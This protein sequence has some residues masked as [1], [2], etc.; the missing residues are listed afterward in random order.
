M[1]D[2]KRQEA[3]KDIYSRVLNREA[4]EGGLRAYYDS[5]LT[6]KQIEETIACSDEALLLK[7][8]EIQKEGFLSLVEPWLYVGAYVDSFKDELLKEN[9]IAYVLEITNSENSVFFNNSE[10]QTEIIKIPNNAVMSISDT[11]KCLSLINKALKEG[12]NLLICDSYGCI[13]APAI[14]VLWYIAIG[15]D[16]EAAS[17]LVSSKVSIISMDEMLLGP[18]HISAAENFLSEDK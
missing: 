9:K 15:M 3:I 18:W 6:V 8:K 7:A 16:L 5:N 13:K 1:K 17:F 11:K 2:L 10:V 12:G 14:A 4:D